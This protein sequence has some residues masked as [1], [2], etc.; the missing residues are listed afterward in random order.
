MSL[1]AWD[2]ITEYYKLGGLH[3][4]DLFLTIPESEKSKIK[5]SDKHCILIVLI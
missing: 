5:I 4:R 1:L 3:N 2:A